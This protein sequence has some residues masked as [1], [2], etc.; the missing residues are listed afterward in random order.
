M[1]VQFQVYPLIKQCEEITERFKMNK[2]LFDS[3]K[4]VEISSQNYQEWQSGS[5][6]GKVPVAV[7]N[8]MK[9][10]VTGEHSD[11]NIYVEGHGLVARSHKLILSMW[12]SPFAKVCLFYF[13]LCGT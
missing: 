2:K 10:L 7:N 9:F 12:S 11:V 13:F 6:P 1:S 4:K 8:L 5:L 3:G